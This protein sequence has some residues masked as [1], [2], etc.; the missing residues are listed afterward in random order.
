MYFATLLAYKCYELISESMQDTIQREIVIEASKEAVYEA[1]AN[2]EQVVLWFPNAIEG[3]YAA[4]EQPVFVFSEHDSKTKVLIV[5]AR[6]YEYFSYRWI[7]GGSTFLGDVSKVPNTLVEF[8]IEEKNG[9]CTV[10]VTESGFA[11]LPEDIAEK[12]F[13]Q[14]SGGWDYMLGRLVKFCTEN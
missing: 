2:P 3:T 13:K 1:I 14:N 12:S 10:I 8:R 5:D 11:S 4:G 7:P 9:A 6:P